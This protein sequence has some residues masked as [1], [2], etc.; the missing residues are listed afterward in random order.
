M[1]FSL[2]ILALNHSTAFGLGDHM[3]PLV[4]DAVQK[5]KN[6]SAVD[7]GVRARVRGAWAGVG[8][9]ERGT[10]RTIPTSWRQPQGYAGIYM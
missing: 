10:R 6:K 1:V 5:N 3:S 9:W 8:L 7:W 4:F 2:G